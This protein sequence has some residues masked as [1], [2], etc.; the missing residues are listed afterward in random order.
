LA[1]IMHQS[2]PSPSSWNWFLTERFL[3]PPGPSLEWGCFRPFYENLSD[4]LLFLLL[5]LIESMTSPRTSPPV[6]TNQARFPLRSSPRVCDFFFENVLPSQQGPP[7]PPPIGGWL[8]S[9]R[10]PSL[11]STPLEI[12]VMLT[13][14]TSRS[15]VVPLLTTGVPCK[16][17]GQ[18]PGNVPPLFFLCYCMWPPLTFPHVPAIASVLTRPLF[19]VPMR[20]SLRIPSTIESLFPSVEREI[21]QLGSPTDPFKPPPQLMLYPYVSKYPPLEVKHSTFPPHRLFQQ[22]TFV[23]PAYFF[24]FRSTTKWKAISPTGAL[25]P[26]A[27][28]PPLWKLAV[29]LVKAGS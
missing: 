14:W 8:V 21:A 27:V 17:S 28:G 29:S 13:F 5:D 10:S 22:N 19:L 26:P 3:T 11:T 23:L 16:S 15:S 6:S 1:R 7:S 18:K 4:S 12:Q 25:R 20:S 2:G 24:L 9:I